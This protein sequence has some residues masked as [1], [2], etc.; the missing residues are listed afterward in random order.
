MPGVERA[1]LNLALEIGLAETIA[2]NL[3]EIDQAIAQLPADSASLR[4]RRRLEE[5][6]AALRQP[7]LRN[8]AALV[9]S[10]CGK[11]PALTPK[12]RLAFADLAA[13][14]RELAWLYDQLPSP[15]TSAKPLRAG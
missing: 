8:I 15:A 7:T 3:R 10:M 6:R 11:D 2:S 5:Q 9:L 4:Y 1:F 14:H 12:I 13:Q